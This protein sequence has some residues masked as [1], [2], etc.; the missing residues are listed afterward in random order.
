MFY[1]SEIFL[2]PLSITENLRFPFCK[3]NSVTRVVK[4]EN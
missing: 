3:K 1:E 2:I 4:Y